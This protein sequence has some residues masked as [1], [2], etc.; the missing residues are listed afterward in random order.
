MDFRNH[1]RAH[2]PSFYRPLAS[3][4]GGDCATNLLLLDH[5][6]LLHSDLLL[7]TLPSSMCP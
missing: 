6:E 2:P 5:V 7:Y 1:Y 4:D 3:V